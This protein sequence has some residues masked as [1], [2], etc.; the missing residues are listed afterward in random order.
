MGDLMTQQFAF[1]LWCTIA[2]AGLGTASQTS[3]WASIVA[4]VALMLG[5]WNMTQGV[6]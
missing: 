1:G 5:L 6:E 3:G 2:G 4:F